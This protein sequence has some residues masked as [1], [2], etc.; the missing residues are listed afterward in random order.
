M[1]DRDIAFEFFILTLICLIASSCTC[2]TGVYEGADTALWDIRTINGNVEGLVLTEEVC[3]DNFI[4][5]GVS[6]GTNMTFHVEIPNPEP[7][8]NCCTPIEFEAVNNET[9]SL[10]SGYG[11]FPPD[12]TCYGLP[13]LEYYWY[14]ISF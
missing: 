9:C 8:I 12:S 4:V 2:P 11:W 1:K 7:E 13:E 10:L 3:G 5:S 6:D 14:R